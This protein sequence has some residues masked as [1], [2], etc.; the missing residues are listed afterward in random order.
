MAFVALLGLVLMVPPTSSAATLAQVRGKLLAEHLRP[1]PLF[2][3]QMPSGFRGA[4]LTLSRNSPWEFDVTFARP[5]CSGTNFCVDF[6]RG[7]PALL[8]Q[9]LHD[10]ISARQV[11]IGTRRV[12]LVSTGHAGAP[13]PLLWQEQ[14]RTYVVSERYVTV[15]TALRT[16]APFVRSLRPLRAR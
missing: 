14:G 3:S 9:F 16:L 7:A 10:A 1:A 8:Q 11:R 6:E 13:S 4:N 12:W 15:D 2:P 5:D